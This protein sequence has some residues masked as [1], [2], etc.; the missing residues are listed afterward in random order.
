MR[1][2]LSTYS[3]RDMTTSNDACGKGEKMAKGETLQQIIC[4]ALD[5][6]RLAYKV[7][8]QNFQ[9]SGGGT[10]DYRPYLPNDDKP[11]D[12]LPKI[13]KP[14]ECCRGWH[15]T[16][17]PL[18]WPGCVVFL[19][20]TKTKMK[21]SEKQAFSTGRL[22]KRI[23]HDEVIDIRLWVKTK[24]PYLSGADLRGADLRGAYLG[25]AYLSGAD[26]GGAYLR[27]ADLR[28][29]YLGG[30]D[31]SGADRWMDEPAIPGWEVKN[32]LLVKAK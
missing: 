29:A 24:A 21:R 5:E 6:G 19:V 7:L 1:T 14:E 26:L 2:R 17:D 3:K 8:D 23:W 11:G 28:G 12:W 27:G 15:F 30:A 16:L 10:F 9:A 22:L 32:G 31:L 18:V 13:E 20:E 4:K 25:G